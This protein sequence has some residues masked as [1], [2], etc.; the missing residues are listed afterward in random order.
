MAVNGVAELEKQLRALHKAISRVQLNP[1][2]STLEARQ[3]MK[4]V[5][6]ELKAAEE[7]LTDEMRYAVITPVA[8]PPQPR[9][10]EGA[11]SV[12]H[13]TDRHAYSVRLPD[14]PQF[15]LT[16][17]APKSTVCE[18]QTKPSRQQLWQR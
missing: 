4:A 3:R 15:W 12:A 5:G 17:K 7:C 16:C 1:E 9:W 13:I 6:L 14:P 2:M 11:T 10:D 18:L 8:A